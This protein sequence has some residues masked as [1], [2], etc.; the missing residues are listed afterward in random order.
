MTRIP[1]SFLFRVRA[2]IRSLHA[3]AQSGIVKDE[4]DEHAS[5][6]AFEPDDLHWFVPR[7]RPRACVPTR[8]RPLAPAD[9]A[10]RLRGA[11]QV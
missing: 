5:S 4:A 2:H 9:A 3:G 1:V 7:H 6:V 10:A 11:A 8:Q